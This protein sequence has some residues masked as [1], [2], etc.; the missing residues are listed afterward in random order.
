MWTTLIVAE[1]ISASSGIG[2]LATNA[3]EFMDMKTVIFCIIVYAVLGKVSDLLAKMLEDL[4]LEWRQ[5][6]SR[7]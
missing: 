3:E 5:A 6:E 2:Y 7:S 1:T 4:C